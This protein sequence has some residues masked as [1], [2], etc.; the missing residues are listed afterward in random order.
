MEETKY[1]TWDTHAEFSRRI[2]EQ[3]KRQ[4][5]RLSALEDAVREMTRLTVS[6]EK[7]AVSLE[8][9]TAEQKKMSD[10]LTAIEEKPAKRWD[11][12]ISGIISGVIGILIGLVSAGII[13]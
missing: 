5:A 13:K 4:D 9:M 2:E 12:V 6:V 10:R 3:E 11:T 8:N 7:I 1:V